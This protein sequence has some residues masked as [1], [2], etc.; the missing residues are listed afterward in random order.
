M[1]KLSNYNKRTTDKKSKT[2][3]NSILMEREADRSVY[4]ETQI[5]KLTDNKQLN[6]KIVKV[7]GCTCNFQ[8]NSQKEWC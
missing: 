4:I 3:Y 6:L 5:L 8:E 7:L 2:T 1:F